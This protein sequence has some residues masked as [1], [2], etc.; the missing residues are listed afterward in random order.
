[1]ALGI[2]MSS[3]EVVFDDVG[4]GILGEVAVGFVGRHIEYHGI[5]DRG[6]YEG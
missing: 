6:K 5:L 2:G 4:V 3:V 1:M